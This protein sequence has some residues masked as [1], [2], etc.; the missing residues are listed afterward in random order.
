VIAKYSTISSI[1]TLAHVM[2]IITSAYTAARIMTVL[3][4]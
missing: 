3:G 4:P 2:T 1:K